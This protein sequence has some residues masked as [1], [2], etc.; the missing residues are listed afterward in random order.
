[1]QSLLYERE[2]RGEKSTGTNWIVGSIV[3]TFR[4]NDD[5]SMV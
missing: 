1:M 3:Q 2:Q 4:K 5:T